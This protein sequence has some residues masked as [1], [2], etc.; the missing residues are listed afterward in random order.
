[1]F[2]VSFEH[3]PAPLYDQPDLWLSCSFS[4]RTAP[5]IMQKLARFLGFGEGG[6]EQV[7]RARNEGKTGGS[8]ATQEAHR[9]CA[10]P[11]YSSSYLV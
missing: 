2:L 7:E 10:L 11:L 1:L 6:K 5:T 4:G 9:P 8:Y 3:E